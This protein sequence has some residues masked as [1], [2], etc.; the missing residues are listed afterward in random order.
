[1]D[2][3]YVAF[4]RRWWWLIL[5]G[6]LIALVAANSAIRNQPSLYRSQST[7][8]VGRSTQEKFPDQGQ[9]AIIDR[10]TA[11]Y[12]ELVKRDPILDAAAQAL[13]LPM[14]AADVRARLLVSRSPSV[15]LIDITIVDTDPVRAA[16]LANE[17][18]RQMVLQSPSSSQQDTQAQTFIQ[19]QLND[20]QGKIT[21]AQTDL[22]AL[23][24]QI[25]G[26]TSA[27]DIANANQ[28]TNTLQ[29]QID[30]WQASYARLVGAIEP[31]PTNLITIA[32]PAM[33][34]STPLPK[35]SMLNYALAF[36][37]GSGLALL[38]A[39][40][41][42]LLNRAITSPDEVKK[43]IAG[44]PVVAIPR[45]RS[46]QGN[47]EQPSLKPTSEAMAAYRSLRNSLFV[48]PLSDGM[49]IAVTSTQ[50]GEGKT[51]TSANLALM[52][53]N[54]GRKVC[55][56]DANV[57]NPEMAH[58]FKVSPRPGFSDLVLGSA[59]IEE[60]CQ[61]THHENLR[62][63]TAGAIP[64]S[65]E[66]LLSLS[67]IASVV[68]TL[69]QNADA[70]VF[71]TAAVGEEHDMLLLA[72]HIDGILLVA[73]AGRVHQEEVQETLATVQQTGTRVV[74]VVLNKLRPARFSPKLLPW[75][76]E[77]R[78]RTRA[79][80]RRQAHGWNHS[81]TEASRLSGD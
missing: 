2:S 32:S 42:E 38:I 9:L 11:T 19:N 10:L 58:R 34:S 36:V 51:T 24:G 72:K 56:V 28:R 40:A 59:T 49:T 41:L 6:A 74:A 5:I 18:A 66:N 48:G 16:A 55:L 47:G 7:I 4:A 77:A 57:R 80:Q 68:T 26:M 78:N 3:V 37:I 52:L 27:T 35:G 73:E 1:M 79:Q 12:A 8:Q 54:S 21:Q 30:T 46:V 75:S 71:D 69:K 64:S 14:R 44:V 43:T 67:N 60:A 33:A 31:S 25:A 45:Y 76:R 23:Q 63:V 39:L 29:L 65:Y 53:A 81:G 70:V 17:I 61:P 15:P 22:A 13:G 62:I 20:L 50:I